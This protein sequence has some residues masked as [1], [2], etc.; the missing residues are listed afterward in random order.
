M[1]LWF[2]RSGL[3]APASSPFPGLQSLV[4]ELASEGGFLSL[5]TALRNRDVLPALH[6]AR[7]HI[8]KR[9][10]PPTMDSSADSS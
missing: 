3:S 10:G 5:V 6:S 8:N 7:L 4:L 1:S 9:V 2:S